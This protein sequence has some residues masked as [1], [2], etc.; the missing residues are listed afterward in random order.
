MKETNLAITSV[1]RRTFGKSTLF[2]GAT[3]A[4]GSPMKFM[5]NF[6]ASEASAAEGYEVYRQSCPRNCWDTCAMLTYVKNGVIKKILADPVNTYT[7]KAL[8]MKG[9]SYSRQQYEPDRVKYPMVQEGGRTSGKWKRVSWDEAMDRIAKKILD[10]KKRDGSTLGV[11][12]IQYSGN[13]SISHWVHTPSLL[14]SIGYTSKMVS[15]PCTPSA[16]DA[17]AYDYGVWDNSDPTEMAKGKYIIIW[18]HNPGHYS[19][20]SMK[21]FMEARDKGAKIVTVDIYLSQT[22]AMSDLFVRIKP[23]SD[24]PLALAMG[25]YMIENNLHD[26]DWL[27]NYSLGF[28]KYEEYVRKEVTY[29]WASQMTGL[30]VDFIQKFAKEYATTKPAHIRMGLGVNRRKNG[31]QSVRAINALGALSGNLGLEGGGVHSYNFATWGFNYHATSLPHPQGSVGLPAGHPK[32]AP[33]GKDEKYVDRW[34]NMNQEAREILDAKEPPIRMA[35]VAMKGLFSNG[36]DRNQMVKAFT[37][38]DLEM[39]VVCDMFVTETAEFADIVL[40]VTT[41]MENWSVQS[42][43]FHFYVNINE[44][45]VKPLGEAKCDQEIGCMLSKRMNKLSPGSCTYPQE[46]NAEE[47]VAKEF[48]DTQYEFLGIKNYKDLVKNGPAKASK[49]ATAWADKKFTTPSGKFEFYSETAEK[50]GLPGICRWTEPKKKYDKYDLY[51][52]KPQWTIHSQFQN[53]D[54]YMSLIPEP[55]VYIHPKMGAEKGIKTGDMVRVFNKNG[56]VKVR[57]KLSTMVPPNFIL[58]YEN[59]FKGNKYNVESLIDDDLADMGP[60]KAQLPGNTL[61][62]QWADIQK[63]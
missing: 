34:L 13:L 5:H 21:Y 46:F 15:N 44:P 50:N 8:C 24:G 56:E 41:T 42:G 25:K 48:N 38:K 40:P 57:A 49:G 27:A 14:S 16:G 9:Y 6:V 47:W 3:L 10:I 30:P 28:D 60:F 29:D 12:G 7:D 23:G 36:F 45:A 32:G 37:K 63:I 17:H 51:T 52:A 26:K 22:A 1:N 35:W 4:A 43:Y 61:A 33:A 59:W 31:G 54:W 2:A 62:D 11:A 18:S 39:V 53:I 55:Y 19:I 58:M 20:H